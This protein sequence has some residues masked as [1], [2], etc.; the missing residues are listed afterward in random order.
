TFLLVRNVECTVDIIELFGKLK[1]VCHWA[2]TVKDSK[3][4][5]ILRV[6]LSSLSESDDT[7]SSLQTLSNLNY[8]FSIFMDYL[9]FYELNISNFGPADSFGVDAVEDFKEY[10]LRDYYCWLKTYCCWYKLKLLDDAADIKLRLLEQKQIVSAVQIVKTVSIRVNTVMHKLKDKDLQESKDPQ[11]E[12]ILNGDS[13]IPTRFIDGVV[14]PVAPTTTKQRLAITNESVSDVDSVFAASAKVPVS[15]IPNMDTLSD[16]TIYSFFA[17]Q[18]NSPQL[19]NDDLKQIDADDL[20]EM[21][22]KWRG[23]FTRECKSPKHNRNKETQRRNVPV[24]TSMSNSLVSQC[25]GVGSYDWSFQAKEEPINCAL[26]AFTSSS[27]SI[28]DNEVAS[29]SKACLE[30]VEARI[31]VYQQNETVFEKD[32]KLLKLDVQLRDN[33][34]VDLRKRF[35]KEKQERDELKLKLDKIQTSS[36]NLS[37]LLANQTNDKT[38][39]GYENQ[40]FTSFVFDSAAMFSFESNVSMP[41]SLV[42]DRYESG[43][44]HHVVPPPYT[45]AFMPFK[46]D[47]VFHDAPTVKE[48]VPTA[49]NDCDYYEKQMVQTPARNH[50]QR[51]NHQYYARMTHPNPHWHVVPTAVLTRFKLV[52]LTAPRPVTT[53]VPHNNGNPQHALKD[54]GVMYN[55]CSRHMTG[56]MSHLTNFEEIIGGYVAFGGNLKGGKITSKGKI[57]TDTECIVLSPD[58]KLPDE[59]QVLLRGTLNESN[60]WHKRLGHINFK[61]MNKLG[62][63]NLVRGLPS[64]VFEDNLTCVACKKGKQ[65]RASFV[66]DDYSRFNSVF[67]LAT[68]DETNPILKTFIT[69]IENQLSLKMKIIRS[70]NGTKFKNQDFN[71]FCGMKGIKRE[72]SV[73]RPPHQNGVAERKNKTLIE[74][75]RTMLAYS[76]LPIPFLAEAV[77]TACYVQNRKTDDDATFEVKEPEF[78]V[79]K[80]ESEVHVS[81][82]SSTKTKKHDDKT[83]REAKGKSHVEL[84]T[85]FRNLR[86]EFEDFSD[87]II[88]TTRVLRHVRRS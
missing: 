26:M 16:A 78:E 43:E 17:S 44:G 81:P 83:K 59:N 64:K 74:A 67:F 53:A 72:F 14:Q 15:T 41:A 87:N 49:L 48:I 9:W 6:K 25:D 10:T 47:L 28:S 51:R 39:L 42:Y 45:G 61:I 52:P 68:K 70:D 33:G 19:D 60:L 12:V 29:C 3:W 75:T 79:V 54:K 4:S 46:P 31:L 11:V 50:A 21:D 36:K 65:H 73:P 62:K 23:H 2:N 1:F 5:N 69:G 77:N 58:F 8:L 7:F 84:S 30:S 56:N 20:E 40:V 24:E 88:I 35:E 66:T 86:E 22:L 63:G 32:I 57:R 37:Q 38:R 82:S 18:S 71:Q 27:S 34:L 55:G 85:G 80:P 13:P 76:L